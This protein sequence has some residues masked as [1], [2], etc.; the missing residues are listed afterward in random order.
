[1][2]K[3]I[4]KYD[5]EIYFESNSYENYAEIIEIDYNDLKNGD[6]RNCDFTNFI[7]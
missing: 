5:N 6:L 4:I 2:K 1:M 3:V 7:K